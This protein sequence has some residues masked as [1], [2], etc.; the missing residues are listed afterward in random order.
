MT[1]GLFYRGLSVDLPVEVCSRAAATSVSRRSNNKEQ[2]QR[3]CIQ[4][5]S[6]ITGSTHKNKNKRERE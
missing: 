1:L 6:N 3:R 4:Y 5:H 2:Q